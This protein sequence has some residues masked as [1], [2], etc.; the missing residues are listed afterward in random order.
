MRVLGWQSNPVVEPKDE[1]CLDLQKNLCKVLQPKL[2]RKPGREEGGWSMELGEM[3][4]QDF[5][6]EEHRVGNTAYFSR[7]G[8]A[9]S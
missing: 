2:F 4:Y 9:D 1:V 6:N 7:R 3:P 5:R 8:N